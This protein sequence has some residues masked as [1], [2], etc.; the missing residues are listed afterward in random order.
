M[1]VNCW[2]GSGARSAARSASRAAAGLLACLLPLSAGWL[3]YSVASAVARRALHRVRRFK[4]S[5]ATVI[6]GLQLQ[7]PSLFVE[8]QRNLPGQIPARILRGELVV[9]AHHVRWHAS[10][11]L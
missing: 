10:F 1:L 7:R 3:T 6:A 4:L 2:V 5:R 8:Y 9:G 11:R